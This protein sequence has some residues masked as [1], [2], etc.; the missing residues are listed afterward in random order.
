[1]E[2][3]LNGLR[4]CACCIVV[5]LSNGCVSA[6]ALRDESHQSL[7]PSNG[8]RQDMNGMSSD[9]VRAY[10]NQCINEGKIFIYWGGVTGGP[11]V[12]N[13]S[14]RDFVRTIKTA[15]IDCTSGI[16]QALQF[17]ELMIEYLK[18]K[19]GKKQSPP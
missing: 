6:A 13:Q 8:V 7:M 2:M 17:N 15:H 14:D 11:I 12:H 5:L 18:T 1:M 10:F 4:T 16:Q 19:Q 9:D 3:T